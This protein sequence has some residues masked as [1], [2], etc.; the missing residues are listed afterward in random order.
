MKE[1]LQAA[2]KEELATLRAKEKKDNLYP[3]SVDLLQP[4]DVGKLTKCYIQEDKKW[5]NAKLLQVDMEEQNA[6]IK[7][8]GNTQEESVIP[9]YLLKVLKEP[10]SSLFE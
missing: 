4:E 7:R 5:K 9:A 10:D 8:Y 1:N 3:L 6:K 2:L